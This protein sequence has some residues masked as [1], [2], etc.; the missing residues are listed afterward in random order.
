MIG[1]KTA[2]KITS[3]SENFNVIPKEC[4]T[5]FEMLLEIRMSP[6]K[7]VHIIYHLIL[8]KILQACYWC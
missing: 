5:V 7:H 3:K 8:F 1:N 6:K 2:D 4:D